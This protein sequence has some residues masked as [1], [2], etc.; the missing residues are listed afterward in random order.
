VKVDEIMEQAVSRCV[1]DQGAHLIDVVLR[2]GRGERILQVFV[3]SE[4]GVTIDQ[5]TAI[6]RTISET[7]S[8]TNLVP[9]SYRLEVS[10][11]GADRPLEYSWQYAKHVGRSFRVQRRTG[12][13]T[14]SVEGTL[15]SADEKE[16][17]LEQAK[18]GESVSIPYG[19]IVEAR[20]VTPW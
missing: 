10:S 3:D 19:E 20:V 15:A 17:T 4:T 9:G 11:P 12:G 16:I 5:C 14:S 13:G 1:E 8:R 2:G 6:S 18:T 7:M